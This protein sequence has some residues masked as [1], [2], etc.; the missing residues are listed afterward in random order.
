MDTLN[1][2]F[3]LLSETKKTQKE[4]T[5][6]L[7]IEKSTFSQW[8]KGANQSYKKHISRIADFFG[9]TTD[10][11]SG[12]SQFRTQKELAEGLDSWQIGGND[13]FD[14]PYDFCG[15]IKELRESQGITIDELASE[16]GLE[17]EQY[18]L[19]EE[20]LDPISWNQAVKLSDCFSTTPKQLMFDCSVYEPEFPVPDDYLHK[21][22]EWDER[23]LKAENDA[24]EASQLDQVILSS[25][26][27]EPYAK[28]II[29]R[30]IPM[31]EEQ[32]KKAWEIL[33]TVFGEVDN[34]DS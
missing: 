1:K 24:R 5:D 12:K 17:P 16:I 34:K 18:E 26:F 10:W 19:C 31:P 8:K 15:L 14:P 9:V 21:V 7:G 13:V 11:L 2:I 22:D 6:Y 30:V 4:L 32:R 28:K 25:T 29:A 33:K 20:G 27:S 23:C 3:L